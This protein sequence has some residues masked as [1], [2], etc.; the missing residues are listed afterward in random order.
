MSSRSKGRHYELKTKAWLE[1][2][3]WEVEL[4]K[5]ATR[6]QKQVDFFG[7]ADFIAIHPGR[8]YTLLGQCKGGKRWYLPSPAQRLLISQYTAYGD[9]IRCQWWAWRDRHKL[10]RIINL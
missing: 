2:E 9:H 7:W 1:A 5:G 4:V 3:G 6:F 10:P 8:P